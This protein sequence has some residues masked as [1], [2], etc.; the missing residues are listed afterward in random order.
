[1]PVPSSEPALARVRRAIG[2]LA[3]WLGLGWMALILALGIP[4]AARVVTVVENYVAMITGAGGLEPR[5]P[6]EAAAVLRENLGERYDPDIVSVFLS[7]A[8]SR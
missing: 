2:W 8:D 5:S 4:L 1:M 7:V 3:P 6:E